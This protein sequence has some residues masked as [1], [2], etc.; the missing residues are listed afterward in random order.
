M[1]RCVC[2]FISCSI[3][4]IFCYMSSL[5]DYKFQTKMAIHTATSEFPRLYTY[6]TDWSCSFEFGSEV[7]HF[8]KYKT[9][10]CITC[11]DRNGWKRRAREDWCFPETFQEIWILSRE[12]KF[13]DELCETADER[14]FRRMQMNSEH[15]LCKFLPINSNTNMI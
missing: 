15:V 3:V 10:I 6:P 13:F 14:L 2:V 7:S 9:Y 8:H 5:L 12:W 1:Y 4:W 11:V